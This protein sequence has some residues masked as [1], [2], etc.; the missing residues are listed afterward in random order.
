MYVY[1][2]FLSKGHIQYQQY[3]I[4]MLNN[5]DFYLNEIFIKSL[6]PIVQKYTVNMDNLSQGLFDSNKQIDF[7]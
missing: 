5:H 1:K 4:K 6:L 7:H 2:N 3:H